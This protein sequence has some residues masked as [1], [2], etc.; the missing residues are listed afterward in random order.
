MSADHV[1]VM[2]LHCDQG[3]GSL[4]KIYDS[5]NRL[6]HLVLVDLGSENGSKRYADESIQKI[7]DALKQMKADGITPYIE[8]VIISHQDFDH[9]SLLPNLT[10]EV[11]SELPGVQVGEIIYGGMRWGPQAVAGLKAFAKAFGCDYTPLATSLSDYDKPGKKRML[12]E[13]D[14]VVFRALAANVRCSRSANDLQRNGTSAVVVVEFGGTHA[15]LPGDATAD[16]VAFIISQVYDPWSK[17]GKGNPTSPCRVMQAPHHGALRTIASNFTTKSPKLDLAKEFG[18]WISAEN[19]VASAGYYSKFKHPFKTVL[20]LL[21][22]KAV[23]DTTKHS[24]VVYDDSAA[25]WLQVDKSTEGKF[26]TVTTLRSPPK[27]ESWTWRITSKGLVQF[28]LEE[29]GAAEVAAGRAVPE[30]HPAVPIA[31]GPTAGE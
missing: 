31:R 13:L 11:I 28:F 21:G 25:D 15:I 2:A 4:V 16:T 26:T 14:G 29:E 3:M 27:R 10:D 7:M 30:R 5:I 24:Y 20:D 19:V 6:T 22:V 8:Y 9:W 18:N 1:D 17:A 23:K 12:F